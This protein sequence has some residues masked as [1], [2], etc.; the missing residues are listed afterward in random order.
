MPVVV[1]PSSSST[2]AA[3]SVPTQTVF[4]YLLDTAGKAKVGQTVIAVLNYSPAVT[5]NPI[6][7]LQTVQIQTTT[8]RN[9]YYSFALIPNSNITPSGTTYTIQTPDTTLDISV[10]ASGGPFQTTQITTSQPATLSPAVTGLTGPI[11]VTGDE[12]VTG[13]LSVTGTTT[14]GSTTLGATTTGA[15][16]T[17]AATVGGDLTI[18]S[19]FR[20]LFGAAVSKIVPGATSISLRDHADANDNLILTDAGAATIRNGLTLTAGDAVITAGRLLLNAAA[21]KIKG[22][23]TSLSLRNNADSADNV[24]ITDAGLVT[25]R[26]AILVPPSAGGTLAASSYGSVPV[27]LA[28]ATPSG[29]ASFILMSSIPS[30]FRSLV[31]DGWAASSAAAQNTAM[32][33]VFN[34]DVASGED[35]ES[36]LASGAGVVGAENSLN[37]ASGYVSDIAAAN[38]LPA[39]TVSSFSMRIPGYASAFLKSW[40]AECQ[41]SKA[42]TTGNQ[43]AIRASGRFRSTAAINRIDFNLASGN[44]VAGSTFTLWGYP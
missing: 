16:S 1:P 14:L 26:N 28:E 13:N 9:G 2:S 22:G 23:A 43:F 19:A 40:N 25:L 4:D 38:A 24:L 35:S 7:S 17:G 10:P 18:S 12:T 27:K 39:N 30:G 3:Q 41:L 11:T 42:T 20:L 15:I 21:A 37:A 31:I 33:V 36:M 44:F 6:T 5:L 34:N 29:V 8:D 32:F